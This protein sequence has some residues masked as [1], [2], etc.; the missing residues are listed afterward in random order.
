MTL[1]VRVSGNTLDQTGATHYPVC[2]VMT[3]KGR[4]IKGLI[5]C[6]VVCLGFMKGMVLGLVLGALLWCLVVVNMA[7]ELKYRNTT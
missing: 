4:A 3:S 6:Y 5:V 7:I 1:T 2:T